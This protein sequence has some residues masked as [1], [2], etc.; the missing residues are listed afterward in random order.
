[1]C[2]PEPNEDGDYLKWS[3]LT[4]HQRAIYPHCI[5]RVLQEVDLVGAV[6]A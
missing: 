5:K 2:D 3:D 6:I 1:M 4:K